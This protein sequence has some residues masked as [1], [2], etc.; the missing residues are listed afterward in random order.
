MDLDAF[1]TSISEITRN[2]FWLLFFFP[3]FLVFCL[4]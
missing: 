1:R 4:C 2:K 3:F